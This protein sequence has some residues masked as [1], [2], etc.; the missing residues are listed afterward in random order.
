MKRCSPP[1]SARTFFVTPGY[2]DS[3]S[4]RTSPSVA[5]SAVTL[6]WSPANLRRIVGSLTI[7]SSG[8]SNSS[9]ASA[10]D[11]AQ[12]LVIDQLRDRRLFATHGAL[13]VPADPQLLESQW[14]CVV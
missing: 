5:P 11:T 1:P 8:F 3:R 4:F 14:Q 13:G 2:R 12:L 9:S 7:T 10:D 6:A